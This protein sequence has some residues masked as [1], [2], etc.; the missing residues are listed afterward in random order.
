MSMSCRSRSGK[1]L[2]MILMPEDNSSIGTAK[3]WPQ[4]VAA[5]EA[6]PTVHAF[7]PGQCP[8]ILRRQSGQY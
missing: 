3:R 1:S 2:P 8:S 7:E 5:S 4:T 6:I